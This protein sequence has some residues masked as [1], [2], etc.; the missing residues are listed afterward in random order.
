[1]KQWA[2]VHGFSAAAGSDETS[3]RHARRVWRNAAG[4]EVLESYS[5]ADMGHGTPLGLGPAE[6]PL[7]IVGPFLFDVGIASS[8]HIAEFWG[9]ADLVGAAPPSGMARETGAGRKAADWQPHRTRPALQV[10]GALAKALKAL[11]RS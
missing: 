1:M 9:V 3:A 6:D 2:D 8:R 10:G 4:E 11:F 5:I 7:G